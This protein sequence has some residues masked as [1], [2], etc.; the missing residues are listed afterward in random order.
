MVLVRHILLGEVYGDPVAAAE[1]S[2]TVPPDGP[3]TVA[4]P[5]SIPGR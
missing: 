3:R 1:P 4:P 2:G 5:T